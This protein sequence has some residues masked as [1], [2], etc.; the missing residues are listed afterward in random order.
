MKPCRKCLLRD[1]NEAD[2]FATVNEYIQSI[3]PEHKAA[4][5]VYE[6]RLGI[7]KS[8]DHLI[9]GMCELCGCYVEVRAAR[10]N[11]HCA[12]HADKW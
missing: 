10:V 6:T 7:C 4:P 9:S 2:F 11:A 3:P 8:C 12:K 5:A 1:A